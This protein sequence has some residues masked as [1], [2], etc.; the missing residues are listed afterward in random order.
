MNLSM[1]KGTGQVTVSGPSNANTAPPGFYMVFLIDSNGVPSYGQVVQVDAAGDTTAPTAPASLTATARTDGASLNWPAA[2]DNVAVSSYRVYRSTTNGFTPG[3]SNR[4]ASVS[5]GTSYVDQGVGTGTY[6]YRVKAV[7]KAGNLGPASP[8]ATSV[9]SGD[10]TAPT[11]SLTAPAAGASLSNTVTVSAS[12]SDAVGVQSVQFQLDGQPL[13]A[14][15]TASPY[16]VS[17]DT[18][19][20]TD[21][22]HSL[23]AVARDASGNSRTST[24]VAV[25]VHNTGLV[26]AYGF[27][28]ASGNTA[29]DALGHRNGTLVGGPARVTTGRFGKALSLDGTDDMV[30]VPDDTTIR[31]GQNMTVEAWVRPTS[32]SSVRSI[33]TKD[34]PGSFSYSLLAN[35]AANVPSANVFTTAPLTAAGP[36]SLALGNWTYVSQT[37]DGTTLKLYI[38]G[39]EVASQPA[40]GTLAVNN[41][42]LKIGGS[43]TAG[44]F[45]NGLVDEVRVY[46]RVRTPAEINADLNTPV[47]P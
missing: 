43:S 6:Y 32:L 34:Q 3:P 47:Q 22:P 20:A 14:A 10:T 1:T 24:A 26:A 18:K 42:V 31:L 28:E 23:T 37:W 7:D 13:G 45:F 4:I 2:T 15:D 46:N 40:A 41:G 44:Q 29:V 17:W 16:S 5:S 36:A 35:T 19:T 27:E 21:G 38:D 8:Q 11:V 9:V 25:E 33:L 12:A 30:T 39:A